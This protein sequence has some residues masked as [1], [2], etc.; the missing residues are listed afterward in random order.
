MIEKI[1][2]FEKPNEVVGVQEVVRTAKLEETY[3]VFV[4]QYSKLI[5]EVINDLDS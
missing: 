3:E 1:S 5:K 2:Y 4:K